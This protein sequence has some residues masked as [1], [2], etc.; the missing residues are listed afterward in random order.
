MN[1]G[2]KLKSLRLQL[3]LTQEE[4]AERSE[5]TKGFISQIE[6]NLSSPSVDSLDDILEALG[7]N[8]GDFF[9]EEEV[10]R[11]HFTEDDYFESYDEELGVKLEWIVPD[12]QKNDMEPMRVTLEEIGETKLYQPFEGEEFAYVLEGKIEL[13]TDHESYEISKGECFYIR[14]DGNRKI[15]NINGGV[16]S[17]IWISSP[18]NF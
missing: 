5:F 14:A 1:I 9:K 8:L 2:E 7:T 13:I 16:S 12:A 4:L 15:K 3:G 18:P 11:I 17:F 6:R 10:Q